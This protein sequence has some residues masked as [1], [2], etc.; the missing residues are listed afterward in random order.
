MA[1]G[2]CSANGGIRV[3]V[4]LALEV[5]RLLSPAWEG[6]AVLVCRDLLSHYPVLETMLNLAQIPSLTLSFIPPC[7]GSSPSLP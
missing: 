1:E 2:S 4:E 7:L 5:P 6:R 3:Q